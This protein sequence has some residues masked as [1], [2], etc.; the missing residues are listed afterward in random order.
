M[1][2][3][4]LACSSLNS[5]VN[6]AQDKMA[7][8]YPVVNVD[9]KYHEDPKQMKEQITEKIRKL[10][11]D[12]DTLLVAM[13]FCGGSW[14]SI[15]SAKRIVIPRVDDCI[16]LLL[17]TGDVWHPNLKESGHMYLRDTDT[18]EYSLEAMQRRLCQQYGGIN[19]SVIFRSMFADYTNVDIIDTGVYDCYSEE[20]VMEAQRNADLVG[21]ALDYVAGSNLL[22]EKLVSGQWDQNFSVIEPGRLVTEKDFFGE[23]EHP[24]FSYSAKGK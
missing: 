8:N 9:R 22:L 13:G 6:A 7:T 10:P 19:G 15:S 4:I 1:N 14:E 21:G 23:D 11:A 2:A 17:Y 24:A 12:I 3:V 20:Y 5:H 18:A 16:T